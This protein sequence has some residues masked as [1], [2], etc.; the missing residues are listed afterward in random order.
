MSAIKDNQDNVRKDRDEPGGHIA[1]YLADLVSKGRP[2]RMFQ[3]ARYL[4]RVGRGRVHGGARERPGDALIVFYAVAQRSARSQ[5]RLAG[6]LPRDA[7]SAG[8]PEVN[9]ENVQDKSH[10][11]RAEL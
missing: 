9:G 11:A 8:S 7:V 6:S 2:L 1:D 3:A 4:S 10:A 5:K